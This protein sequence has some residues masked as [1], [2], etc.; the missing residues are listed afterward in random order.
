MGSY[1]EAEVCE[2]VGHYLLGKLARMIGTKNVA[3]Y[4]DDVSLNLEME[5]FFP[6]RKPSKTPLYIHSE[7]NHP[8]SIIKR[9]PSISTNVFRI[10]HAMNMN[11]TRLSLFTNQ[12]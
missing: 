11:S 10:C 4:R 6:Y 2:F 1:D 7:S 8:P 3:F 9:L 5:K 12:L